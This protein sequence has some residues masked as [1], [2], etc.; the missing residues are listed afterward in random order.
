MDRFFNA[1]FQLHPVHS[2]VVH[3]PIALTAAALL[4]L[5]LALW[6]RSHWLEHA[7]FFNLA[8]AAPSTVVAG[9]TGIYD[10]ATRFAGAAPNAYL[11]IFLAVSLL[12]LA[13]VAT[14]GR[15]R[16][17]QILWQPATRVLYL[18]AF[19]SSFLLAGALGFL[20]GV[21]VYGY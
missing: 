1:L 18:A 2:M 21:I 20:G 7:A 13:S 17:P 10:N 3:F 5:V 15:W 11:K 8:L 19:A 4:F 16:R 6:R 14:L 12:V 9:L